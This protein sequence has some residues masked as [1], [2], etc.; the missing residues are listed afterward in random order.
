MTKDEIKAVVFMAV[1]FGVWVVCIVLTEHG[2]TTSAK[3]I[4]W[5]NFV[6]PGLILFNSGRLERKEKELKKARKLFK[7]QSENYMNYINKES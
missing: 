1:W 5:C 6:I 7:Q 4:Y 2:Y 3:W